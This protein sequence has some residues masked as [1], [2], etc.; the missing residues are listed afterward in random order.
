MHAEHLH[1][2]ALLLEKPPGARD[3]A[4]GAETGHEVRH[5][6][7]GLAPDFRPRRL[8]VRLGVRLVDVLV[9]HVEI[10]TLPDLH[11]RGDGALRRPGGRTQ[12]VR[13][14]HHVRPEEAQHGALLEGNLARQRR[15]QRVALRVGDHRQRHPGVAGR[16]LHQLLLRLHRLARL[17]VR[18]QVGRDAVLHRPERVVPLQLAVDLRVAERRH[19]AQADQRRRVVGVGEQAENRVVDAQPVIIHNPLDPIRSRVSPTP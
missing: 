2:V 10:G 19:A 3:G 16:R 4:A 7:L 15:R 5:A 17:A 9:Q 13:Q 12:R 8:V 14:L 1:A 11:G 18:D 6:A